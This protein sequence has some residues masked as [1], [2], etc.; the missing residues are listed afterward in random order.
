MVEDSPTLQKW[1]QQTPNVLEDIRN[2][3]SFATRLRWGFSFFPDS[4]DGFG[5]TRFYRDEGEA[6]NYT[7]RDNSILMLPHGYHTYVGAPGFQSYYLWFLAGDH[8]VQAVTPD[9]IQTAALQA[10]KV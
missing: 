3:P 1:L 9:A 5:I 4:D 7:V 2:D 10:M 6:T 8:R